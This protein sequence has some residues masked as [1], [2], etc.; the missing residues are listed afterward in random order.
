MG[1]S[2]H[3]S[4]AVLTAC[5]QVL[6]RNAFQIVGSLLPVSRVLEAGAD[7]NFSRVS[8]PFMGVCVM[9]APHQH[10]ENCTREVIPF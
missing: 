10:F 5:R 2:E 8:I 4:P 3:P 1:A 9:E 7:D 6:R